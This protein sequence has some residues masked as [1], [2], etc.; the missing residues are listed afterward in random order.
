MAGKQRP[1][2]P[3]VRLFVALDLPAPVVPALARWSAAAF[4]DQPELRVVRPESLHVTLVF[5][6][7]QYERDVQRIA[8]VAFAEPLQPVELQAT[9]VQAVPRSR[10][11][12]F[13]LELA[14][15]DDALTG[16]QEGLSAR[17]AAT[18]LYE[19]EKRPFW[20]HVTLA[21]AKR[22]ARIS[23]GLELPALPA[24]LR[25]PFATAD[26]TLYRST[27]RPAGAVYE[28]LAK[29]KKTTVH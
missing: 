19:P 8:E 18:R 16:W 2:S 21:R 1:G 29:G 26:L 5:L 14:D 12:L 10:P 3:R 23:R 22:G 9:G 17:L 13:A 28:P 24:E 15:R 6:G 11:R 20:P 27:L 25:A 4:G 7:Y